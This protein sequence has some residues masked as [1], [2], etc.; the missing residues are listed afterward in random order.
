M[1]YCRE[2]LPFQGTVRCEDGFEISRI[3][4]ISLESI[5]IQFVFLISLKVAN[6]SIATVRKET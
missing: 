2:A 6:Q 1:L 4:L 3:F 5:Y